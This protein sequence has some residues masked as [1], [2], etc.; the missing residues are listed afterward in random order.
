MSQRHQLRKVRSN[1]GQIK[2]FASFNEKRIEIA[3]NLAAQLGRP[4][5]EAEVASMLAMS[6]GKIRKL[7]C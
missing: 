3:A 5:T 1:L 4:A 2:P 6:V 7:R